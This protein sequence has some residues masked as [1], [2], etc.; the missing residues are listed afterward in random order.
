M[1]AGKGWIALALTTF[2]TWRPARVL[3][4]AY[5]FGGVTML[6]FHLQG[7]GVQVPSQFL[8]M[9]PY[10]ATIVVL[11]LISR[12]A[13]VHPRQHAGVDRQ[14]LLPGASRHSIIPRFAAGRPSSLTTTGADHDSIL[15]TVLRPTRRAGAPS[16]PLAA[17]A[18]CSKKEGDA[19][20]T[21]AAPRRVAGGGL[22]I[23]AGGRREPDR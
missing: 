14:A 10:L 3:L 12:N 22:G 2:A 9:L 17:L 19:A 8:T 15:E 20:A 23:V 13:H 4:G 18:G 6:Q 11:V 7:E 5:L 16:P 21:P 1:I